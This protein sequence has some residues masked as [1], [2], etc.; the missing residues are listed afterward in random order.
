MKEIEAIATIQYHQDP[1]TGF[2]AYKTETVE[3]P[4][5]LVLNG[6]GLWSIRFKYPFQHTTFDEEIE[7]GISHPYSSNSS[8]WVEYESSAIPEIV[9]CERF[10]MIIRE[11]KFE[12]NEAPWAQPRKFSLCF[13]R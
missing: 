8:I 9:P 3:V 13:E 1:I 4:A 11:N 10:E 6:L 2:K 12:R 7:L 5:K